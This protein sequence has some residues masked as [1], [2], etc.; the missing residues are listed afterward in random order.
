VVVVKRPLFEIAAKAPRLAP[1]LT[2]DFFSWF[3]ECTVR[4]VEIKLRRFSPSEREAALENNDTAGYVLVRPIYL[5]LTAYE[6]NEPTFAQY[7][8]ELVRAIDVR[9][10]AARV[11]GIQFAPAQAEAEI[12]E[13]PREQLAQKRARRVSTV[14]DDDSAIATLTEGEKYLAAKNA[15]AAEASF[16]AVLA[17]YPEQPRAWYGLGMVAVLDHDAVRAKEVFGRLT[18]GEYAASQDPMVLSWSHV[19]LGRILED[20]GQLDRA[21]S[22]FQAVL[23]VEGA[24]AQAQ[25]AAQRGLGELELRKP[26]E[27]P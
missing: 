7:F 13:L 25:Q 18:S 8:P 5:G 10:E 17:R 15:R 9:T 11:A 1:D 14:P 22:E 23:A 12:R 27:R 16:Q 19:Y 4:A 26:S 20:E 21:K 6:K 2:D 24:P 3:A